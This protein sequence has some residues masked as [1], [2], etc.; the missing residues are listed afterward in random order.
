MHKETKL[1]KLYPV[2]F[3][4]ADIYL[5]WRYHCH[6]FV[7]NKFPP[8]DWRLTKLRCQ[9]T[10]TSHVACLGPNLMLLGEIKEECHTQERTKKIFREGLKNELHKFDQLIFAI[11]RN[12]INK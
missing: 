8:I 7:T 6:I 1:A 10:V 11:G 5:W 12:M 2:L 3:W 9:Y 4:I